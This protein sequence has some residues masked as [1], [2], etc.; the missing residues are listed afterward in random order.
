MAR[1]ADAATTANATLDPGAVLRIAGKHEYALA[2]LS[3]VATVVAV[4][5]RQEVTS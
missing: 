3:D 4:Y 2:R 5:F 1:Q